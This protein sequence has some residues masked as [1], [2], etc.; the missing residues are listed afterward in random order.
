M[1]ALQY[2]FSNIWA[3]ALM[4]FF[5]GA[6]IFV[7]ELGHFLAA[8]WRGMKVE[9][10]SIGFG[11]KI[12]G[13]TGRDGVDY[14]VAW[15]PIG[16]YV[17]LPQMANMAAIEGE[18]K[19]D[20]SKLPPVS[21]S[22][23]V[24]ALCAGA[25]FNILFA[26]ALAT[27]IWA[28]GQQ[29]AVEEKSNIISNVRPTVETSDGKI[30]PSPAAAAGLKPGDS[31]LAVDGKPAAISEIPERVAL[32]SGRDE[33]GNPAVTL[34][35]K[36][37]DKIFDLTVP[38][39]YAG[40]DRLRDIGGILPASKVAVA[41]VAPGSAAAA[42]GMKAGD[43]LTRVDGEPIQTLATL[44]D[45]I[46]LTKDKPVL[47]AYVRDGVAGTVTVTPRP[48]PSS[49]AQTPAPYL[50]GV[51]MTPSFTLVT[52]HVPPWT[53]IASVVTRTWDTIVSLA[54]PRSDIGL[55]KMSGPIG[56]GG[57]LIATAKSDFMSLLM[58]VVLI[59]VSLAIFN[60]LPIPVLDGGHI[61]F[62]TI[63]KL[64]GRPLPARFVMT[65]QSVFML[66]LFTMIIYVSIFDVR[67]LLPQPK[68][69][70]APAAQQAPV[71]PAK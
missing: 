66:L 25:F 24:L 36:R 2:I 27:L 3:V 37:A 1:D 71:P 20:I 51:A 70:P 33:N 67:R 46:A 32:G 19:T 12:F 35:I 68:P 31:V 8:R 56:I 23:K 21:W 14:R 49:G 9:R 10:F 26:F 34:T 11:P 69:A 55:S 62:A 59:N 47:I 52:M 61:V 57:L 54:S 38:L 22:S 28:V 39:V 29:G 44:S 65:T 30:V 13:W 17:L 4:V 42:A 5:F 48:N 41:D 63:E 64:R 43:I 58:V 60:M 18:A 6:S 15:I 7:H 40:V 45:H 50:I 53:Q 16:G